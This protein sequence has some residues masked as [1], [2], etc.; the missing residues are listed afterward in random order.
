MDK[1]E[2]KNIPEIIPK[3][4][5]AAE[6]YKKL[7]LLNMFS[8]VSGVA[9]FFIV[10]SSYISKLFAVLVAGAMFAAS[11]YFNFTSKKE[12]LRLQGKYKI[13]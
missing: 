8:M 13:D 6:L 7:K 9:A 5:A 12:M 4:L 10:G 1:I 11:M 2:A 3:K